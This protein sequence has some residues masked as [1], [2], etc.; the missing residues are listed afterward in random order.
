MKLLNT[1]KQILLESGR[2][3]ILLFADVIDDKRVRLFASYHQW[4]ERY[5]QFDFDKIA[6]FYLEDKDRNIKKLEY[7]IRVGIPNDIIVDF[8]MITMKKLNNT[9]MNYMVHHQMISLFQTK[10]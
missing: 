2:K 5:G 7:V 4:E 3:P 6:D 1:I 8:L 9:F 10:K